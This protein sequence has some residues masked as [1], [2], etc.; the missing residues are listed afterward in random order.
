MNRKLFFFLGPS[1][2][3]KMWGIA[4][5]KN[6]GQA[7][8]KVLPAGSMT[9]REALNS[10]LDEEMSADHSFLDGL[11]STRISKGLLEKYGPDRV[12]DTPITE[13]GFAGIGVGAAYYGLRP[14]VEFMIFY[15]SMQATDHIINSSAKSNYMSAGQISVPVVFRRPNG[16][17]DGVGAQHSQVMVCPRSWSKSVLSPYSAEDARGLLK[18][19]IREPDLVVFLENELLYGESFPISAE[20]LD[21]SFCLPIGKAKIEGK[22]VTIT[23][24]SKMVGHAPQAAEILSREGIS[25]E[26]RNLRSIRPLDRATI[27]ASARKTNRRRK[28]SSILT[29]QWRG[30]LELLFQCLVPRMAVPQR[31]Q[32]NDRGQKRHFGAD[33]VLTPE[34][35]ALGASCAAVAVASRTAP[36]YVPRV[37]TRVTI[38]RRGTVLYGRELAVT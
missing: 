10:A 31:I 11:E 24:F 36:A 33:G 8:Q 14:V 32:S 17:N 23:S 34:V 38:A 9:V 18:A 21:S 27:S 28:A 1:I 20:V 26:V 15:F 6:I 35:P 16:A 7:L 2:D 5:R 22:Y 37:P 13:A 3:R 30:L 12:L 4:R 19:A 29:H 25:A